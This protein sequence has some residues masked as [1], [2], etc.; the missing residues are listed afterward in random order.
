[1]LTLLMIHDHSTADMLDDR[2]H[3]Y[4]SSQISLSEVKLMKH[5]KLTLKG[6]NVHQNRE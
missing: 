3:D 2:L 4:K 6:N 1:M 5:K